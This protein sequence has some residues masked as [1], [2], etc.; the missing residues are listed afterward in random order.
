MFFD[1]ESDVASQPL[2]QAAVAYW[3]APITS[4]CYDLISAR[5]G[6]QSERKLGL[7]GAARA[8]WQGMCGYKGRTA[9]HWPACC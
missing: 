3:N 9:L 1:G 2:M 8:A 6:S 4:E 5:R 7:R